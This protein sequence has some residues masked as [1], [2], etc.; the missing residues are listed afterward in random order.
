VNNSNSRCSEIVDIICD[1]RYCTEKNFYGTRKKVNPPSPIYILIG[2]AWIE[3][4]YKKNE[5]DMY[6]ADISDASGTRITKTIFWSNFME[7]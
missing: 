4:S 6:Y 2:E 1:S 5:N 3:K 7:L